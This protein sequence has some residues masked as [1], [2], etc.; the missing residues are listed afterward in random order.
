MSELIYNIYFSL[1]YFFC[2]RGSRFIHLIRT[3]S[4]TLIF[5][6][7]WYHILYMCQLSVDGWSCVPSLLFTYGQTM[8]EVMKIK[9]TSSKDAMH[10]LLYSVP[11]IQQQATTDP[12]LHW[13]LLD[14]HRKV[15]FSLLW[16]HWYFSWVLVHKVLFVPFKSL[17][18]SP[19]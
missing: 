10:V 3:D 19:V 14:T 18:P 1:F 13:R 12:H 7:E 2:R 17:F 8:M 9:V 16:D 4:N 5:M 6:A 11:P 15:W